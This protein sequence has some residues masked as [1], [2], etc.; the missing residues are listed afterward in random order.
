MCSL[1]PRSSYRVRVCLTMTTPLRELPFIPKV[2]PRVL[3]LNRDGCYSSYVLL[4][5]RV[6]F[7]KT[8]VGNPARSVMLSHLEAPRSV[9]T[10]IRVGKSLLG[11]SSCSPHTTTVKGILS[12]RSPGRCPGLNLNQTHT[13]KEIFPWRYLRYVG[14][15]SLWAVT[16]AS[17][18]RIRRRLPV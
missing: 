7:S 4:L 6:T 16:I 2:G 18:E 10:N 12:R 17:A 5:C 1:V 3:L 14:I 15:A 9:Q 11:R 13:S 8:L